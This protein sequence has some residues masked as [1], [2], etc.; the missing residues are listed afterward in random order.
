MRAR[1]YIPWLWF[2]PA[3]ALLIPFFLIPIALIVRNSF[4]RDDPLGR[5]IPAFTLDNYVQVLSDP[6][7]VGVFQTTLLTA[8]GIAVLSLLISYPFA[9]FL[10]RTS[11]RWRT[12]LFWTVFLPIYVSVIM[13]VFGWTVLMS[14]SG[15][16]NQ[17]VLHLGL[18]EQPIRM[19][20]ELTGMIV[21][22][23]HRYLPLVIIP[24]YMSMQKI[25]DGM[26]RA[27]ASLGANKTRSWL[28]VIVPLSLPGAVAG[29]QLVFAAVLSDYV[30]PNLM[31]TTRYQLIAPAIYYEATT[32]ARWALAG[33]MAMIVIAVVALFLV[34]MN[35]ILR[36]VAPWASM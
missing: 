21:G 1:A 8:L 23:L 30:I 25:E 19:M 14:D 35:Y 32:N 9:W 5:L 34:G 24:L 36:R 15:S 16:F 11:S 2:A 17:M 31:G 18:A 3:G 12:V 4:Y 20:N 7:Y 13:R 22:L 27:S 28:T 26:L 10:V 29:I 33:A 6:Y